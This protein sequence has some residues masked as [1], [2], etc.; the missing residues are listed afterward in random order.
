MDSFW[1][2]NSYVAGSYDTLRDFELLAQ[3]IGAVEGSSGLNNRLYYLA[4]PP[5]VFKPV[6]TMIKAACMA[7]KGRNIINVIIRAMT[8]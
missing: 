8:T 6:T 7:P 4:L 3:E 2:S 5:S 1:S